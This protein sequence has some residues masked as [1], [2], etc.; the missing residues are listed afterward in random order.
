MGVLVL[1][2]YDIE[3]H[4]KLVAT[5]E[6][7]AR[8]ADADDPCTSLA[9]EKPKYDAAHLQ[10]PEGGEDHVGF[11]EAV[12]TGPCDDGKKHEREEATW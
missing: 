9:P 6:G 8:E 2:L 7:E 5:G 11:D 1:G 4:Q 3:K 12:Q 10:K